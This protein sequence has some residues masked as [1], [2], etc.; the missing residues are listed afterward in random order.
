MGLNE[1]RNRGELEP[2]APNRNEIRNLLVKAERR[3]TE[4]NNPSNFPDTRFEKAYTSIL[5][6]ITAALRAGGYRVTRGEGHHLKTI[7][8]ALFTIGIPVE[9]VDYYHSIRRSRNETLYGDLLDVSEADIAVAITEAEALLKLTKRW[10]AENHP[11]L[12]EPD[13]DKG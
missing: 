12:S 5:H 2:L 11:D 13:S 9:T 3:I 7:D 1:M 6:C 8:T 10:L 4:A